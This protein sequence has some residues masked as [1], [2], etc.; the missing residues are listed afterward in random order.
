MTHAA[1]HDKF[2]VVV[3]LKTWKALRRRVMV[4]SPECVHM[5]LCVIFSQHATT[6]ML[7]DAL[8]HALNL[9]RVLHWPMLFRSWLDIFDLQV[10]GSSPQGP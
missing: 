3:G 5:S 8:G 7:Q 2:C 10:G 1:C 9:A 6:L 4:L